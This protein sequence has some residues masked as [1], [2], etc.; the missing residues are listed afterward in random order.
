MADNPK[1]IPVSDRTKIAR[2]VCQWINTYPDLDCV[3]VEY[4][5]LGEE[6]MALSTIR[7]PYM[8]R[9]CIDGSYEAQ[10]DFNIVHRSRPTAGEHRLNVDEYLNEIAEWCESNVPSLGGNMKVRRVRCTNSSIMNVRYD[11]GTEDHQ[12][13]LTLTFYVDLNK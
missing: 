8:T 11:D 13:S 1:L 7:T 10:F 12:I 5:Y 2:A 9:E 3:R 4:E 6:G